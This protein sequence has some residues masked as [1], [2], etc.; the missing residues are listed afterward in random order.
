MN[1]NNLKKHIPDSAIA[2]I[3]SIQEK[4]NINTG[5]RL[6]H[7]LSQCS[8]ESG[9]FTIVKEDLN[10]SAERLQVIFKKYFTSESA[11]EYAHKPEKIANIVYANRMGNGNQSSGDG[12]KYSGK[13]YI[14]LTGKDNYTAF[15][16]FVS[17]DILANP[18]LI[19]TTYPLL[20]A[21]WFW[22]KNGLNEIA[23]GGASD[24]IVTKLTN[25]INGG[26]IG[27]D[28]RIK[29]FKN[30]YSLLK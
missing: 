2:Q 6:A 23:D 8:H 24:D 10:Y 4:F 20:S 11:V 9:K 5:L 22:S 16:K 1:L 13:G 28:S 29:E 19:S 27:L 30:F 17:E 14:Q 18:E 12:F 26:T 21:A 3:P 15:D 7:F 25:R